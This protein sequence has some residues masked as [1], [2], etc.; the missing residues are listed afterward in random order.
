M[1]AQLPVDLKAFEALE[2]KIQKAVELVVRLKEEN[3]TLRSQVDAL[4]GSA[5]ESAVRAKELD[6]MRITSQQLERELM[7]LK[8][9]R[10]QVLSKVDGL[11]TNL[12]RLSLD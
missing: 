7:A 2:N 11:L 10:I 1:Q 4:Q 3:A 6:G 8:D 9:E 12:E 5:A